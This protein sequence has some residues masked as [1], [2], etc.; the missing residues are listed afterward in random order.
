MD[1]HLDLLVTLG[2]TICFFMMAFRSKLF[3]WAWG[4]LFLWLVFSGIGYYFLPGVWGVGS[5]AS[6]LIPYFYITLAGLVFLIRCGTK[7]VEYQIWQINLH[8]V[9]LSLFAVS[10]ILL[11]FSFLFLVAITYY[12]YPSGLTLFIAPAL[13]EMYVL[14]PIYWV[15]MQALI[16]AIFY[17]HRCVI[18]GQPANWLSNRQLQGGFLLSLIFQVT[19][20]ACL[21]LGNR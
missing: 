20:V 9:F 8:H 14:N 21:I 11:S 2:Y 3:L 19:V 16:M 13:L 15:G 12:H 5:V 6:L 18:M 17:V 4:S 7:E 10:N 1:I